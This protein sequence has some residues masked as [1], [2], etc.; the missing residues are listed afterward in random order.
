MQIDAHHLS[1]AAINRFVRRA[2]AEQ[3]AWAIAGD[4]GLA[5]VTSCAAKGRMTTLL[6]SSMRE[7]ALSSSLAGRCSKVKALGVDDLF[8]DVL[9]KLAMLN[10]LVG[11]DWSADIIRPEM[12]PRDLA[13][14]LREEAVATFIR[15]VRCFESVWILQGTEGPTCLV[16]KRRP[17]CLLLPCWHDQAHAEARIVG[18]LAGMVSTEVPLGVFRSKTMPWLTET[19]RLIAPGY[20]AGEGL[21]ELETG[22][23]GALLQD[24]QGTVIPAA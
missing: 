8:A 19:G 7:V 24:P 12:E 15:K 22:E 17:G 20:C 2:I 1:G 5:R 13:R 23:L 6:W 9:P 3:G 10:R 18:P 16:S 11:T 14:R 21:L 4:E